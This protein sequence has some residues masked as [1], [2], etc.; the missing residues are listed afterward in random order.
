MAQPPIDEPPAPSPRR[1]FQFRLSTVFLVTLLVSVAAA[2]VGGLVQPRLPGRTVPR[3]FF[4]V[5]LAAAPLGVTIVL[6]LVYTVMRWLG[7][8]G[9]TPDDGD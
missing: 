5:M 2:A 6:S 7:R 3:E 1:R 8:R 9:R 4:V